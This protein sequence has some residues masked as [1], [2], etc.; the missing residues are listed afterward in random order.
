MPRAAPPCCT[1]VLHHPHLQV[2]DTLTAPEGSVDLFT[3]SR[4]KDKQL[5]LLDQ[6]WHVLCR[7]PGNEVIFPFA[8]DWLDTRVEQYYHRQPNLL[9]RVGLT[10]INT[11]KQ[12]AKLSDSASRNL[13]QGVCDDGE[14]SLQVESTEDDVMARR[15]SQE[16]E[17]G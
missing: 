6:M 7:E 9:V 4:S 3:Q 11:P 15:V 1:H 5:I 10:V 16:V 12:R 13:M 2:R 17:S 8:L 14:A